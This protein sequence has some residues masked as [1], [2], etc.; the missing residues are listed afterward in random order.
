MKI[1]LV[2]IFILGLTA[3][4]LGGSYYGICPAGW[5]YFDNHCYLF[6]NKK[7]DWFAARRK[8]AGEGGQLAVIYDSRLNAFLKFQAFMSGA[9]SYLI[10][11]TDLW[12]EGT[13]LWEGTGQTVRFHNWDYKEP[14][15]AGGKEDCTELGK[16]K[17]Y[18]WNDV[19]CTGHATGYICQLQI[20]VLGKRCC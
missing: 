19:P 20:Q 12:N 9:G 18:R 13:F 1:C 4:S 10:G 16:V 17:A 3:S 15:N 11:L 7:A 14:N 5:R 6:S 2:A 8:C